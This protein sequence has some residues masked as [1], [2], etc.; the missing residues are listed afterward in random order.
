MSRSVKPVRFIL[1]AEGMR[2]TGFLGFQ[3][4]SDVENPFLSIRDQNEKTLAYGMYGA[5]FAVDRVRVSR[6]FD[7]R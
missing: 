3:N 1:S 7:V 6:L 2:R 5:S 4:F